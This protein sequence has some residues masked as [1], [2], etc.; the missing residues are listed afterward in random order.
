MD[1]LKI[2]LALSTG[3]PL[4]DSWGVIRKNSTMM[5]EASCGIS[6]VPERVYLFHLRVRQELLS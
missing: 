2:L 3:A 4:Q 6:K 5:I 1:Q